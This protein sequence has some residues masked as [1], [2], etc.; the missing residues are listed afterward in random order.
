MSKFKFRKQHQDYDAYIGG[1]DTRTKGNTGGAPSWSTDNWKIN[2]RVIDSVNNVNHVPSVVTQQSI[3]TPKQEQEE[4]F[5][6]FNKYNFTD[7]D[8][9]N[10]GNVRN[11]YNAYLNSFNSPYKKNSYIGF[12]RDYF[13][14]RFKGNL[15]EKIL[16]VLCKKILA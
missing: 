14:D 7:Q 5:N 6:P 9:R 1:L 16:I 2:D 8:I 11:I 15:N 3:T 4:V 13:G 10:F 12:L